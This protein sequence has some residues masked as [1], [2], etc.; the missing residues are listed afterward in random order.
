MKIQTMSDFHYSSAISFVPK[1][2]KKADV[3]VIAGDLASTPDEALA[4]ITVIR[5]KR[6][7][8][9][10]YVLGNHE[11][12]GRLWHSTLE[13]YKKVLTKE[14]NIFLLEKETVTID[15]VKFAGTTLWTDLDNGL[16]AFIA[17]NGMND[18]IEIFKVDPDNYSIV[19]ITPNDVIEEHKKCREFL[20][21]SITADEKVV[22]VSH[23]GPSFSLVS[24]EY[25]HS[26]LN[27]AFYSNLDGFFVDKAP[28]LFLY[29]HSHMFMEKDLYGTR[30]V[31]NP[32]GYKSEKYDEYRQNF[33]IE[34]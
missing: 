2:S 16:G 18:Y 8:P 21:N 31:C 9:V 29:G 10:I 6:K 7:I 13:Q 22:I 1:L 4:A 24:P 17:Y 23:H 26:R 11:Y 28:D 19:H 3:L 25:S 34:I 33:L 12:Y 20:Y 15:G 5:K 14:D 32:V 27:C 30:C